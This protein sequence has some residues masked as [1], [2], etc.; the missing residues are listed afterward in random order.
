MKPS[1]ILTP[2][3]WMQ[4]AYG[5]FADGRVINSFSRA[6]LRE[7]SKDFTRM[8]MLGAC[9]KCGLEEGECIQKLR[10]IVN[11][12]FPTRWNDYKMSDFN[13]HEDTTL[14]DVLLV[15]KEAGL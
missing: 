6:E 3:N 10:P 8:C 13:D 9:V 7:L 15:L 1:E 11:K 12:H 4:H 5:M 2:D 14:E